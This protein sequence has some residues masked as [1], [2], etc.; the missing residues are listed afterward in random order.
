MSNEN[1]VL[2]G[3]IFLLFYNKTINLTQA[4]LLAALFTA[5]SCGNYGNGCGFPNTA[6]A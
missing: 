5:G 4:L 3:L 2:W 1:L 6:N